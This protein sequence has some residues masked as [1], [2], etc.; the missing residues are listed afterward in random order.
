MKSGI[1]NQNY[2]FNLDPRVKLGLMI[3]ISLIS[4]T[5]GVT[6]NEIFLRLLVMLIPSV[7][8]L[9][10][11]KHLIGW[12]SI[13][14][15]I[16]AW[17]GEAFVTLDYNQLATLLIFVPAG[18]ITRFLPSLVMG[19]YLFKT[20]QVEVLIAGLE[21]LKIP[22]KITIPIAVMFRF[23]PTIKTESASIKDA[24]KMRGISLRLA[25]KKPLQYFEY[26]VVPLLNS[27]VKIGNELTV[28]SITRGLNLTYKRTSIVSLKMRWLDWFFISMALILCVT[29]YI[30]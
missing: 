3:I 17:Y 21:R 19:Y 12:I 8:L 2:I 18:I 1:I 16:S 23:V 6:G 5:G 7:L 24:M 10:I 14:V 13:I 15:T 9:L 27:V 25:F 11:D 30:V 26:R 29:Y 22:R 20:T 4:L 28:A